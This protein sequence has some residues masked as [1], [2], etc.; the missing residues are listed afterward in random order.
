MLVAYVKVN[1]LLEKAA[2]SGEAGAAVAASAEADPRSHK[3]NP[4]RLLTTRDNDL[5]DDND[6]TP[7]YDI[8]L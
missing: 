2:M 6:T 7:M 4:N 1:K 3:P 8:P 5:G